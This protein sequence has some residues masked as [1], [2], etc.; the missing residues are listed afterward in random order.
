VSGD[1]NARTGQ[2]PIKDIVRTNGEMVLNKN[3]KNI[4]EL[5]NI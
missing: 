3:G 1:F 4:E 2:L 5:C